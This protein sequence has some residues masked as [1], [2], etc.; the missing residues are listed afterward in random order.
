[1]NKHSRSSDCQQNKSLH[2]C[3]STITKQDNHTVFSPITQRIIPIILRSCRVSTNIRP[4]YPLLVNT[5]SKSIIRRR[6]EINLVH[7]DIYRETHR[8]LGQPSISTSLANESTNM[9]AFA[10]YSF[11]GHLHVFNTITC[12]AY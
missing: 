8:V 5:P 12:R 10:H 6:L 4:A 11:C 7:T 2:H 1:M 9:C 3:S